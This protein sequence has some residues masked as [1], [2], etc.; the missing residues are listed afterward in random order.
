[1]L[2]GKALNK[3]GSRIMD[4]DNDKSGVYAFIW[5]PTH[6]PYTGIYFP[7]APTQFTCFIVESIN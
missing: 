5:K 7:H 6:L 4:A 3:A 1:L 2:T